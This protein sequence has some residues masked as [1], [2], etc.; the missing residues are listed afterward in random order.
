[1]FFKINSINVSSDGWGIKAYGH[2][3]T[4]CEV[5]FCLMFA[6]GMWKDLRLYL[7][8]LILDSGVTSSVEL[9]CER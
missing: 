1:M 4:L 3:S 5:I 7:E 8:C 2:W 6:L 9:E